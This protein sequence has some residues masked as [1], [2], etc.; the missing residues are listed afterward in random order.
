MKAG[1]CL[2]K[3]INRSTESTDIN[4]ECLRN[5]ANFGNHLISLL[6]RVYI[7]RAK[8]IKL[9]DKRNIFN[10]FFS[11]SVNSNKISDVENHLPKTTN[12]IFG[13]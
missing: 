4:E 13:Q 9:K 2:Y 10:P 3:P 5:I 1:I 7:I 8:N 6:V 11:V 12:P